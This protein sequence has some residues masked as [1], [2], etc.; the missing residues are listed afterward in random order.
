MFSYSL[1]AAAGISFIFIMTAL[2]SATVFLFPSKERQSMQRVLMGFSAGVMSAAAVWSLLLPAMAQAASDA[3][4]PAWLPA[5]TGLIAGALFIAVIELW[6]ESRGEGQLLFTAVTLHNI[7]EGLA[8]GLAFALAGKGDALFA[9]LVLAFGIGVQ[10]FPEGAA[11][12]LPLSQSGIKRSSAFAK[13][14]ASGAVEPVFAL[15]ALMLAAQIYNLMPWLLS[16]SAGAMLYVSARELLSRAQ[17][18][19]GAFGYIGGFAL[20]MLLD[21]ALS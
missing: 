18:T 4:F 19:G 3:I 11:V 9:A 13:G 1:W 20:M 10:N 17:S 7:P 21:T 2:G 15:L 12:S 14:L 6:Q 8:V 16:F 5:V